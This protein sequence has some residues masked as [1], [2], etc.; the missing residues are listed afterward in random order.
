MSRSSP[1]EVERYLER[2]KVEEHVQ[3][4]INSAIRNKAVDPV[5]HVAD[6][7]EAAAHR[8]EHAAREGREAE[9]HIASSADSSESI[10]DGDEPKPC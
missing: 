3:A 2:F 1:E 7:L 10:I 9:P 5:L 8:Q 4:A 6:E